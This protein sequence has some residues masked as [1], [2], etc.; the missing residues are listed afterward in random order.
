MREVIAKLPSGGILLIE[1][2][3]M[4]IIDSFKQNT[5]KDTESAGILIGEYRGKHIRVVDA[6]KPSLLDRSTRVS[7]D[8]R[9]PHHQRAALSAWRTSGKIQTWIGEWHTHP[10]N[11]P[12]PSQK[13][14]NCWKES[15]P[16]RPMVLL[17]QGRASY[18]LGILIDLNIVKV[19]VGS[20]D[21]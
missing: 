7:F 15:L 17:I 5:L 3:A 6:T 16:S 18:W 9:S 11:H 8:R 19:S 20:S 2:H 14:I 13:D 21:A 12:T 4:L 1:E 10:E